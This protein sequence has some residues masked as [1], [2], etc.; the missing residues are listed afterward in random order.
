MFALFMRQDG[1][2]TRFCLSDGIQGRVIF[3]M[4]RSYQTCQVETFS[5]S[6]L[7]PEA[8]RTLFEEQCAILMQAFDGEAFS[9][10][11]KHYMLAPDVPYRG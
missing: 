4:R 11:G 8:D 5:A 2:V 1:W 3:G 10:H 7:G 9:H 6:L